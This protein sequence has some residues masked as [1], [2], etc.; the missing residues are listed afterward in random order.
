MYKLL[1][2]NQ[3]VPRPKGNRTVATGPSS[4]VQIPG[5][6][7]SRRAPPRSLIKHPAGRRRGDM[8]HARALTGR[9]G[10]WC[11][12]RAWARRSPGPGYRLPQTGQVNSPVQNPS[13]RDL[14]KRPPGDDR[15]GLRRDRVAAGIRLRVIHLHKEP[16]LAL[17]GPEASEGIPAAELLPLEP[18]RHVAPPERLGDPDLPPAL[19][20]EV[21]VGSPVPDEDRPRPVASR[22]DDALEVGVADRVVFGG[23]GEASLLRVHG[24]PLRDRP[25]LQNTVGLQA[26]VVVERGRVVHLDDEDRAISRIRPISRWLRRPGEIPLPPVIVKR[27]HT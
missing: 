12:R 13:C 19:S 20:C 15:P 10:P 24:R 4:R 26:E 27:I 6:S 3:P 5:I 2:Q 23:D 8:P 11:A 7:T 14:R 21:L 22:R 17:P 18:D 16:G 9:S 25:G 1:P